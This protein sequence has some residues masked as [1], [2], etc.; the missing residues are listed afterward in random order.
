MS[1][2]TLDPSSPSGICPYADDAGVEPAA[3]AVSDLNPHR[4]SVRRVLPARPGAPESLNAGRPETSRSSAACVNSQQEAKHHPSA[5]SP[6]S[7]GKLCAMTAPRR[8]GRIRVH[9]IQHCN[10]A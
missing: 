4:R 1:N 7:S 8:G 10:D 3:R 5:D 2:C 9:A 6:T